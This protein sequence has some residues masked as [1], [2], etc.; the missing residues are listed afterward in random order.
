MPLPTIVQPLNI[1]GPAI[2]TWNGYVYY[3]K[4]GIKSSLQR[5]TWEESNDFGGT[6][7]TRAK[8]QKTVISGRPAGMVNQLT[9][10]SGKSA[11]FPY[12]LAQVGSSIFG[13]VASPLP[14][15]IQ[16]QFGG[17]SNTGQ[18]I[19]FVRGGMSKF[20]PVN[21]KSQESLYGDLEFTCLGIPTAAST[22]AGAWNAIADAAFADTSY[23]DTQI[24]S[25]IYVSAFGSS[26]YNAMGSHNGYEIDVPLKLNTVMSDDY[27]ITDMVIDSIGPAT[28]KFAPSNL[29]EAQIW[30]LINAQ[31]AGYIQPGMSLSKAGTSLVISGTGNGAHTLVATI[32]N[33]GPKDAEFIY[34]KKNNRIQQVAFTSKITSTSGMLNA[35]FTF[36]VT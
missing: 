13:T 1:I 26:P 35:N 18:T 20:S 11:I 3:F 25:D 6:F 34:D 30:T 17:A 10:T 23:D 31:G 22:G 19:T 2:I 12:K 15:V 8:S 14:L 5:E 28:A 27:G 21:L 7:D 33:A 29:T 32:N 24:I 4:D 16:T 9:A 36:V